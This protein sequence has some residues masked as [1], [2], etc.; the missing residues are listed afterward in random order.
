MLYLIDAQ[1]YSPINDEPVRLPVSLLYEGRFPL[2]PLSIV[3][4]VNPRLI[5][6]I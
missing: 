1:L 6:C 5:L 2:I 4:C 3:S